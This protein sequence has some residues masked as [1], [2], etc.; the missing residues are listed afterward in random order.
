MQRPL[1]ILWQNVRPNS[2]LY[3]DIFDVS[4]HRI[5]PNVTKEMI[6]QMYRE[7]MASTELHKNNRAANLSREEGKAKFAQDKYFEAMEHFNGSVSFAE[8]GTEELGLAFANRSSCF[9]YLNMPDECLVD[10]ELAKRHN[11][12]GSLM[13]KLDARIVKC[14]ELKADEHF[15]PGPHDIW[16]PKLSFNEHK[17]FAGVADCLKIRKND[18]FG[19]HV[20]TTCDLKIGQTILV[21]NGYSIVPA[22]K[23][24]GRSRCLYCYKACMNFIA[25]KNCMCMIFCNEGCMEK[26][27]H[28]QECNRPAALSRKETFDLI[29]R[30]IFNINADFPDVDALNELVKVLLENK[31]P[32]TD[33]TPSQMNFCSLFQLAHNHEKLSAN[34]LTCLRS[35]TGVTL[36]V[37]MQYDEFSLKY[38]S[39]AHRRFLQHLILH[40]FHVA[41]HA[42]EL[43]EYG[44]DG[45]GER[46]A[47]YEQRQFA[48][49]I[50]PFGSYINHSCVPNVYWF[51]VD[52][53]LICKV[54][55]PIKK[56]EQIF[57][58]YVPGHH[59]FEQPLE[60]KREL[61]E[62]YHFKCECFLC[63]SELWTP[64]TNEVNLSRDPL[65]EFGLQP[66]AMTIKRFRK[67]TRSE[68]LS[69]EKKAIEFLEKYDRFHPVN[70]TI[71]MQN[72]LQIMWNVL[73]SRY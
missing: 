41:E 57:R 34:Q 73:A 60:L 43:F 14:T 28:K 20:I 42:I 2:D 48:R 21:E 6:N 63:T 18:E 55:R 22:R 51:N 61:D 66:S 12:P 53:R 32:P 38:R 33:L 19:R 72:N 39:T 37:L 58:S 30:M 59:S 25:C 50:Y 35:A 13:R 46:M 9:F 45:D 62:R 26:S 56:G 3:I 1:N 7:I 23:N 52:G 17:D 67:L 64:L 11:Y 70:D 71:V 5:H 8:P 27:F 29:M 69:Y 68:V 44:Q 15:K 49:G 40:L 16:E 54:I 31:K 36:N 65:Y 24:T 47:N 4:S 10:I